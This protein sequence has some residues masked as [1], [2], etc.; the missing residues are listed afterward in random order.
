[1]RHLT[2]QSDDVWPPNGACFKLI[3]SYRPDLILMTVLTFFRILTLASAAAATVLISA[4]TP[5]IKN[6]EAA[7]DIGPV[8]AIL[9]R[10]EETSVPDGMILPEREMAERIAANLA[11][12]GYPITTR[13]DT[14]SHVLTAKIGR[15]EAGSTPTGFSF[16]FGNS[17]PRAT[18]FQKAEIIPMLCS[19][20]PKNHPR[21]NA[22]LTMNFSADEYLRAEKHAD[23]RKQLTN[24]LT[25]DLSTTCFNLL[26]NLPLQLKDRPADKLPSDSGST[27]TPKVQLEID[28]SAEPLQSDEQPTQTQDSG[29]PQQTETQPPEEKRKP[30]RVRSE[31]TPSVKRIIIHNQG[32]PVIL[33]FGYERQ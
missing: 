10:F 25:D 5:A 22:E 29:Q 9:L 2:D 14:Y 26:N 33:K 32:S 19:L 30:V 18:G 23:Q 16:S 17:D 11:I 13:A 15:V 1:M 28:N 21:Q 6:K 27:W 8:T 31:Q 20:A 4:C 3:T 12:W 7:F 24:L